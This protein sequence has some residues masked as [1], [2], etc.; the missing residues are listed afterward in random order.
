MQE[1]TV[2]PLSYTFCKNIHKIIPMYFYYKNNYESLIESDCYVFC[3]F[4]TK[5]VEISY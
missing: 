4:L 3:E 2:K 5:T 1:K